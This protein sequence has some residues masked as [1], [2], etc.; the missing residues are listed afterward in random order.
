M[1]VL[2]PLR[3]FLQRRFLQTAGTSLPAPFSGPRDEADSVSVDGRGA[4]ANES[5][6]QLLI[7]GSYTLSLFTACLML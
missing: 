5:E 4:M 7:I 1:M 3:V 6:N 2:T